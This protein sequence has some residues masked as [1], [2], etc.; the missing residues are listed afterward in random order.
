MVEGIRQ[1]DPVTSGEGGEFLKKWGRWWKNNKPA[2]K[3]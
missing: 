2:F 1:I 3:F